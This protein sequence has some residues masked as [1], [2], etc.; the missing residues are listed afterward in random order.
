VSVGGILDG[1]PETPPEEPEFAIL[2]TPSEASTVVNGL[3]G[4]VH[5]QAKEEQN[6]VAEIPIQDHDPW[7]GD[8]SAVAD[9]IELVMRE[10]TGAA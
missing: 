3:R 4:W 9:K 5:F 6:T 1:F 10:A 2:L 7:P 8:M